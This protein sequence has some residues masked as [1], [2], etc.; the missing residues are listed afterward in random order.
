MPTSVV[1]IAVLGEITGVPVTDV[2]VPF[3][4]DDRTVLAARNGKRLR[5]AP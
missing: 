2:A 1:D 5:G 4:S 3:V